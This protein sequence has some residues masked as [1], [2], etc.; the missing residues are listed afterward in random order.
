MHMKKNIITRMINS[1][2]LKAGNMHTIRHIKYVKNK[3][4]RP[5]KKRI[6]QFLELNKKGKNSVHAKNSY[7]HMDKYDPSIPR[8]GLP[9]ACSSE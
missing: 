4:I 5:K 8:K 1:K 3:L 2:K 6:I 9:I 7:M